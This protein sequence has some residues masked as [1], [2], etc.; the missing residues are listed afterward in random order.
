MLTTAGD[1]TSTIG[2]NDNLISKSF[3]G[4]ARSPNDVDASNENIT[5]QKSLNIC[6]CPS[7][8]Y[9]DV[10]MGKKIYFK[11]LGPNFHIKWTYVSP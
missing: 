8:S 2:E 1:A 10:P 11:I 5:H 7:Y 4:A 9:R 3:D 6:F